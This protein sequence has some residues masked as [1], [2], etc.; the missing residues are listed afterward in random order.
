MCPGGWELSTISGTPRATDMK[1]TR[2]PT[3]ITLDAYAAWRAFV[4]DS[5]VKEEQF[6]A[7]QEFSKSL[8]QFFQAFPDPNK[9]LRSGDGLRGA[10]RF[11]MHEAST[12]IQH[13]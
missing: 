4:R 1:N 11:V 3:K 12:S 7:L 8:E 9:G 10:A 6:F 2:V 13:P 5:E